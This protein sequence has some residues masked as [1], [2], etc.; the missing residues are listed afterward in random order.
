MFRGPIERYECGGLDGMIDKP[1][2]Q[3]SHRR[4][5]ENLDYLGVV[6]VFDHP[7]LDRVVVHA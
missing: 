7:L 6:H 4:A 3:V 5:D 1:L 2:E